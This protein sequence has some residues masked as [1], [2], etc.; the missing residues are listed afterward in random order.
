L[1][2]SYIIKN[3]SESRLSVLFGIEFNLSVYDHHLSS[4]CGELKTDA[5]KVNDTWNGISFN[6]SFSAPVCIWHFPVETVSDSETGI[7]KT[8]QELCLLFNWK[9]DLL[10]HSDWS[11]SLGLKIK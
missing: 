7:E 5:L 1:D 3:A 11:I 8:Y 9:L 10:A 2:F 6:F 4:T